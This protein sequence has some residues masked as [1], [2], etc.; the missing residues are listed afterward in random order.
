MVGEGIS[1]KIN[2]VKDNTE[3]GLIM[4]ER[5]KGMG[6]KELRQTYQNEKNEPKVPR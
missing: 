3:L 6:C 1:S 2:I 5:D 4:F